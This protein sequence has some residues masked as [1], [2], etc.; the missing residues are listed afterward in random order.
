MSVYVCLQV[1]SCV[2]REG[3]KQEKKRHR[4]REHAH[5]PHRGKF[6]SCFLRAFYSLPIRWPAL[7][8]LAPT[9]LFGCPRSLL[10]QN[11]PKSSNNKTPPIRVFYPRNKL[12]HKCYRKLATFDHK[13]NPETLAQK[14][15][16]ASVLSG[17]DRQILAQIW[18]LSDHDKDGRLSLK[19]FV[20]AM[21]LCLQRK[22]K[23]NSLPLKVPDA[24]WNGGVA[25]ATTMA[26]APV[27]VSSPSIQMGS[28]ANIMASTASTVSSLK[29]ITPQNRTAS[30]ESHNSSETGTKSAF[31]P[32]QQREANLQR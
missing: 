32:N 2:K 23:T 21:W 27:P 17:L 22:Q 25:T 30:Q 20:M 6:H 3:R 8:R 10:L 12:N 1:T 19:E 16:N 15:S 9:R 13:I 18:D 24:Y 29:P 11:F 7:R 4:Q 14:K 28:T 31:Q 5:T 26:P